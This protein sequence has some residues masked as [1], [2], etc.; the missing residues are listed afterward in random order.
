MEFGNEHPP[1]YYLSA[2]NYGELLHWGRK[3]DVIATWAESEV[4]RNTQRFA[5][6]EAASGLALLYIG[7]SAVVR[8]P[9][10]RRSHAPGV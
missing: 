10:A 8:A 9:S 3:R 4:D 7:F 2:F 6:L 1:T 5:F